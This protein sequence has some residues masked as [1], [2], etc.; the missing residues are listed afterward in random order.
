MSV[1]DCKAITAWGIVEVAGLL[2]WMDRDVPVQGALFRALISFE[3]P[4]KKRLILAA[5]G[6]Q[7]AHSGRVLFD[8]W[9]FRP[10]IAVADS[11]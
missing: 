10:R 5:F 7:I 2:S 8:L 9:R 11:R 4:L 3:K 6:R 1:P